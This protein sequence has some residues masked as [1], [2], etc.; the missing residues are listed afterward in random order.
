MWEQ[1]QWEKVAIEPKI[2][3]FRFTRINGRWISRQGK[4]FF[5]VASIQK[6]LDGIKWLKKYIIDGELTGKDWAHTMT[7]FRSS[8]K[9]VSKELKDGRFKIFDMIDSKNL[10]QPYRQR[11]ENLEHFSHYIN[12][13]MITLADSDHVDSYQQFKAL[14]DLHLASGCDG[15]IIKLLNGGYEY[16]RS[17]L[18]LKVK[19]IREMD[20]L[21]IGFKEGKG[22]YVGT[23]GSLTVKIPVTQ[24]EGSWSQF[25]TSVSG[26]TDED[27]HYIWTNRKRLLH[28]CAEVLYRKVSEKKARL[29]EP[30]L[31]RLRLDKGRL[32]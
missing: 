24:Q 19:P 23:L 21:I 4:T 17:Q 32:L 13:P 1:R 31:H 30:R 8:K 9:D 5:N 18:W 28:H 29:I 26:M 27:R 11:R 3:G 16:K 10:S 2:D 7:L 15:S 6:C 22:K 20:C 25:T 14:H 12:H